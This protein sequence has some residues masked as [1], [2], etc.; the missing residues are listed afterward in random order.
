MTDS[1]RASFEMTHPR[2]LIAF[3]RARHFPAGPIKPAKLPLIL[4]NKKSRKP[5]ELKVRG[6]SASCDLQRSAKRAFRAPLGIASN[7]QRF[8]RLC[9]DWLVRTPKLREEAGH[10]CR[11]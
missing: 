3:H 1:C 5:T 6:N 7:L 10:A 2:R 8:S 11:P 4:A 9:A